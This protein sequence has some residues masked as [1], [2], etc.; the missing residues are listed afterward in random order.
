M[1]KILG[2][3]LGVSSIGWAMISTDGNNNEIL[4][5]G[6]RIVPLVTDEKD[7]FSTGNSF[8]KN[9]KRTQSRQMRRQLDRYQLRRK[10][11][12][13]F[14]IAHH[15][16]PDLE[17]LACGQAELWQ[18]RAIAAE[19]KVT[20]PQLGRILYHL[21]QRRGYKSGRLEKN[22]DKAETDYVAEVLDRHAKLRE[23]GLT[24]G[25]YFYS[26]L[27]ENTDYRIKNQVF[28][29][30]A[31]MEEFD[32]IMATQRKFYPELITDSFVDVLRNQI[33]YYQRA[34]K[35]QKGLVSICDFE[36]KWIKG[37]EQKEL[38]IGPKVAPK[39]S[40]LF[41]LSKIWQT[42]NSLNIHNK[43][44]EQFNITLEQKHQ[45]AGLLHSKGTL[46]ATELRKVLGIG[47]TEE[48][49]YNKQ[50]QKGLQG[51]LTYIRLAE[52]LGAE[53]PLLK[54]ELRTR[55]IEDRETVLVDKSSGEIKPYEEIDPAVEREP[56]YQLWHTIY[57]IK[58]EQEC[59]A[60]LMKR[61]DLDEEKASKLAEIDF[62][63][64]GFGNLSA[65]ALRK[66]LPY[67]MEGYIY[68][69]ACELAGY[70]H[71]GS[72][73]T[74]ER[75]SRR[76]KDSLELLPKN[77]LRQPIVEKILNQMIHVV[78]A[79]MK[80][81]G[82]PDEIRVE[83]A[84]ELK[85]SKDER[86]Q[87]F[88]ALNKR[89]RENKNIIL[90]LR[91]LGVK[92]TRNNIIK[93]RLFE[94]ISGEEAIVN[95]TCV[96]CGHAF[97]ISA[98]LHGNE[99][100]V[101][102]IIPR[103]LLY[104]DSQSN[105][106]LSH[107]ACNHQK[108]N[109]TAYD[110]MAAKGQAELD[111]YIERVNKLFKEQKISYTKRTRLL[112]PASK[113]P[114]D[115]IE[116]QI[117][118]TQYISR[119]SIEILSQV[120]PSVW[121][122]TGQVTERLRYLWGWNDVL[123]NLQFPAYKEA[124]ASFPEL[125]ELVEQQTGDGTRMVERIKDWDKRND[126]RHHAIDALVVACTQQGFIQRMN[127]LSKE[128]VKAE[129]YHE[130]AEMSDQFKEKLNVLEKY[131][132]SKRPFN[133]G[134]VM[135]KVSRI[136]ISFKSGKK[137]ATKG[138]RIAY[139]KGKK[140]IQEGIIVPRGPLSEETVY[141]KINA[142]QRE[143][144]TFA[145]ARLPLK[146]LF[147]NPDLIFKPYIKELV[148][149]R[150][151]RHGNDV[152]KALQSVSKEPI[153]LNAEKTVQLEWAS[154]F[155][156]KYVVKYPLESIKKKDIPYII[157]GGI[158][159]L[160]EERFRQ[161]GD[162]AK[163]PF[164]APLYSDAA[165]TKQIRSVRLFPTIDRVVQLNV[166]HDSY[167]K[168]GNNHHIAIYKNAEGSYVEH[169]CTFWHAV[170]RKKYGLP[171]VIHK[172]DEVWQI[173]E[174]AGRDLPESFLDQLPAPGWELVMEMQQNQMFLLGMTDEEIGH[175]LIN[176]D[177]PVFSKNLFR[178]QKLTSRD[179][180]FRH[181]LETNVINSAPFMYLRKLYRL[182]S[183]NSLFSLNPK[184]VSLDVLGRIILV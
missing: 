161:V 117:R 31:Y 69:Q 27:R 49:I 98:A 181:H 163:K 21:N 177:Y 3:D 115:F 30:E 2:L 78:N 39:S 53:H 147:E 108:G 81:W 68:S 144:K 90:K 124:S 139:V 119:K 100:D 113:I 104:D 158:K 151:A 67:L 55:R 84:R 152:R 10:N 44:N 184:R 122:S 170:E 18:I 52:V 23:N 83:L 140:I 77:S 154:C 71:S 172:P 106:T 130:I 12:T 74:E 157:D 20:L 136:L 91:E 153:W 57:S 13:R 132:L 75:L 155:K 173:I 145:I 109:R 99:V 95:A 183:I 79:V 176:Q 168:P 164:E 17:L 82:R 123:H 38:F 94:E 86:N 128:G 88:K 134:Q 72:L 7:N 51:N 167:V 169:L 43:Y 126:H 33:I 107:R 182:N 156:E 92:E 19:D 65:K 174:Q 28:P 26:Q 76:L 143:P 97:G 62:T 63:A 110:Y 54:M 148:K 58:D 64:G 138:R 111:M 15:M 102:H 60:A 179:Y 47:K 127:N 135:D 112:T 34:L 61:F 59:K 56:L 73:T 6:S 32:R 165:C 42:I 45:I 37:P 22:A 29:R 120:S 35:S 125:I 5:M 16:M 1:K 160:V 93:Y 180:Y 146:Y 14:L 141:G 137:V 150:L 116:R 103:S 80:E 114:D 142:L 166:D 24:I 66:I 171:V 105:K 121:A 4:G 178:V 50:I 87:T 118:Q 8:S 11:L 36:G 70:N 159:R 101:E 129:M 48:W 162:D 133:T 41:Q 89:E 9:Q 96:Y 85:Q 175:A 131:L 25:Q 46:T 149:E 40:P